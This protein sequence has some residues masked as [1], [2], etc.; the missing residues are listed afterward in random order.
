MDQDD[1]HEVV[2]DGRHR[3]ALGMVTLEQSTP[4]GGTCVRR[5]RWWADLRG[6]GCQATT[7]AGTPESVAGQ[8][9]E[10]RPGF[11]ARH[12]TRAWR[13]V[14]GPGSEAVR[15][16]W[17]K[18]SR[19]LVRAP[20]AR[21]SPVLH[22]PEGRAESRPS[23]ET[24]WSSPPASGFARRTARVIYLP[25]GALSVVIRWGRVGWGG[26]GRKTSQVGKGQRLGRDWRR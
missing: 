4:Q 3:P 5:A 1:L 20:P 24:A 15:S 9:G 6:D 18:A 10:H 16:P 11:V 17:C 21:L 14:V 25:S 22:A 26:I 13:G 23:R 12:R 8:A 2:G 7:I 19:A